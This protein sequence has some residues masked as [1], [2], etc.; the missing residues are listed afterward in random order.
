MSTSQKDNSHNHF[1]D[2]RSWYVTL[3]IGSIAGALLGWVLQ[4]ISSLNSS[5]L[6]VVIGGIVG[7]VFAGAMYLYK[8]RRAAFVL[9][10]VTVS[11]PHFANM[12]FVVNNEHRM[13]AW[14]LFVETMTR[15]STQPLDQHGG[16]LREALNS[17]Y[18]LFQSTREMLK[19]LPPTQSSKGNTVE[20]L[21]IRMLNAELRPFLSKWHR[22]IPLENDTNVG[23]KQDQDLSCRAELEELRIDLLEYSKAF[24]ELANVQQL[25]RYYKPI[26]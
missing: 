7:A 15:V 17:L 11:V 4:L 13:A 26:D 20:L 12:S 3:G 21:A 22:L 10:T 8:Q 23:N 19:D 24:G 6:S 1:I 2:T 9:E 14:K 25:D 5:I 18:Q 16:H